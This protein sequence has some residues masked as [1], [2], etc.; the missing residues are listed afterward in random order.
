MIVTALPSWE[1]QAGNRPSQGKWRS[2]QARP[3]PDVCPAS[4]GFQRA[5]PTAAPAVPWDSDV[6]LL[7]PGPPGGKAPCS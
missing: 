5:G 3:W 4:K 2:S 6:P 1:R 7:E